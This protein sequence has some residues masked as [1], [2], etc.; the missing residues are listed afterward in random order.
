MAHNL[1]VQKRF[2]AADA[3][4]LIT[5]FQGPVILAKGKLFKLG[6]KG[7]DERPQV[8]GVILELADGAD[9]RLIQNLFGDFAHPIERP[10]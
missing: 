1:D 6:A 5:Q 8:T 3:L 4:D 7:S 9:P 10:H 2:I